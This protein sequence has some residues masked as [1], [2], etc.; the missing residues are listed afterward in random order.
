[1]PSDFRLLQGDFLSHL[2]SF[3]PSGISLDFNEAQSGRFFATG[4][5]WKNY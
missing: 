3:G 4:V 5:K 1:V 2:N